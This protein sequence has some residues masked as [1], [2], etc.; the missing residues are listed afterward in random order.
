[1]IDREVM[2]MALEALEDI[3]G[4]NKVDVGAINALRAA[5][6]HPE[7]EPVGYWM[8]EFNDG[9]ATLYEVPQESV[10]GRTY[11]NIPVYTTPP[12]QQ[13]EPVK[14]E[15]RMRPTWEPN[16]WS[17]WEK[18]SKES[19]DDYIKTPKLHDWLYEVR[20][21]YTSPTHR[22]S[23]TDEQIIE[24]AKQTKSA[25]PGKDGYILPVSFARAI[26]AAHHI[27]E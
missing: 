9:A 27:K 1:M 6:E 2:Q 3:F 18:C 7:Q 17:S 8:G 15:M 24:I 12:Q 16:S 25:E 21:I 19:A 10:F 20:A 5:L 13:A 26:E 14:Y 22:K 11:R 4:K 23:L